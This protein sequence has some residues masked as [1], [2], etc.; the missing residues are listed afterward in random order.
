MADEAL[1]N[2][3][4]WPDARRRI[5]CGDSCHRR[6]VF[7]QLEDRHLLATVTVTSG[8]DVTANDGVLTLREAI[9]AA[10]S[11]D[12]IVFSPA[13]TGT[14]EL[15]S[16][17]GGH[18]TI[19]K[20]LTIQGPGAAVLTIK[21]FDSDGGTNDSDGRRVFLVD[22][23]NNGSL[24][25]V[26]LSGLTLTNGDPQVSDENT[27]GG[28]IL[29]RENLTITSSVI[30]GNHGPNGGGIYS[31][32]G[33]LTILDSTISG[34]I[35]EDG[36][37]LL[38]ESGSAT[39]TRT[40]FA[41]NYAGNEGGGVFNRTGTLAIIDSTIS[42]NDTD[43]YGGGI[44]NYSGTLTITSSTISGNSSGQ[45]GGGIY[46]RD[47]SATIAHSTITGNSISSGGHSGG[48]I[49][50][51]VTISLN[52]T[53]VAG[54]LRGSSTRDDISNSTEN[55][56]TGSFNAVFSLVGDRRSIPVNNQGGSQI[57]TP[58]SPVIPLLG[59]LAANGGPTTTHALLTGS[60]AM[61]TGSSSAAPGA[62]GIPQFD[63]RGAPRVADGNGSGGNRIDIG[64][65]EVPT[66]PPP[67]PALPGDYNRND[68]VDAADYVL[69]R[70]TKNA[71][72][73]A[74]QGADGNGDQT[75][76]EPDYGV[77]TTNFGESLPGGAGGSG[78]SDTA[79]EQIVERLTFDSTMSQGIGSADG[80][81]IPAFVDVGWLDSAVAN[82]P[83]SSG[84]IPNASMTAAAN[85]PL[86]L[87]LAA[88]VAE[89][90]IRHARHE[91]S[92]QL[93]STS[94]MRTLLDESSGEVCDHLTVFWDTL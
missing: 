24:I 42:G 92:D 71:S 21:A 88:D 2:S 55:A 45:R 11:G 10:L 77:W 52:H 60:P 37:G 75:V 59:P 28:A 25:S 33:T 74:F 43:L 90:D 32:F 18:L 81:A 30:S 5:R 54:N 56:G 86:D 70:K 34:N 72:V 61:D 19:N 83:T 3:A 53:I 7:E 4:Q 38:L 13:I 29:N 68:V 84:S 63:Q 79:T 36:G 31:R 65:F 44:N 62:N 66:P 23:G 93:L 51:G 6:L 78:S 41:N 26:S 69:W 1:Q 8:S 50:S 49:T 35:G 89:A 9:S 17:S 58:S 46:V 76:N 85:S 20:N 67:G 14:I 22:N 16:S 57:G 12:T 87:L 82:Q 40:T 27:G 48:G 80:V 47:G 94:E 15:G 39:I 64:A 73:A 91:E